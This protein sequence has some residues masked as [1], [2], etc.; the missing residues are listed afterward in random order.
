MTGLKDLGAL[1]EALK[2]KR[3]QDEA[4]AAENAARDAAKPR[5][6]PI[7]RVEVEED[8]LLSSLSDY[9]G[10]D[11]LL[12]ADD[13]LSWARDGVSPITVRRLK[14]GYWPPEAQ[15]D[16]HGL[17]S[18]AARE[19]LANFLNASQARGFRCVRIVHGKGLRSKHGEPVLKL[20]TRNW[21]MQAHPVLAFAQPAEEAGGA[22]VAL[23]LLRLLTPD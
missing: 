16:L 20:K 15:L 14:R 17:S 7:A 6:I 12:E 2:H 5:P 3:L 8:P 11:Q 4:Q 22:G 9:I 18:E 23:V 13:T 1:G 21:L 19:A 10:V